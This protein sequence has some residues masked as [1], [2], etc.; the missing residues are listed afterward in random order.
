MKGSFKLLG[1]RELERAL[2]ELPKA[3]RKDV[4]RKALRAGGE[5]I[6]RTARGLVPVD[7]GNLR[8]SITVSTRLTRRQS[9]AKGTFAPVEMYVGPYGHPKSITQEFGTLFHPPQPYLGP[10]F[11][12]EVGHAT[13]LIGAVLGLEI[14]KT[15]KRLAAKA[16]AGG[17]R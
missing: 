10:A 2:G 13:D 15:A 16:A 6:A 11:Q 7:E 3:T 4:S 17:A 8:E 5:A 1:M 12:I 9:R 14:E